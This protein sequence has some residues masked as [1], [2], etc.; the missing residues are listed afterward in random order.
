MNHRVTLAALAAVLAIS[1]SQPSVAQQQ[2]MPGNTPEAQHGAQSSH[3]M[4]H[5]HGQHGHPAGREHR[6]HEGL[7]LPGARM[8]HGIDLTEA[9]RDTVF[10]IL[11]AQAPKLRE[12][13]REARNARM[14]LQT[15]TLAGELDETRL[16]AAAAR[17]SRSMTDLSVTRART[18]NAVFKELTPE[19]Q[20]QVRAR[21]E[22]RNQHA[23][24]GHPGRA[25][26][27]QSS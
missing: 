19:Q 15:L 20:A 8:L 21:L 10:G 16:Q 1:I 13:A 2:P 7:A 25:P 12:Q 22:R 14:E 9:Q 27:M 18:H 6:G 11:H 3:A 4:Q 5:R 24:H 23:P 17:A 26:G